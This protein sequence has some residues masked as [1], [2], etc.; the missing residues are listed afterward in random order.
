MT[1]NP[2][3]SFSISESPFK[4]A[5]YPSSLWTLFLAPLLLFGCLNDNETVPEIIIEPP[6]SSLVATDTIKSGDYKTF[7]IGTTSESTYESVN[8]LKSDIGLEY[9][10]IVSNIYTGVAEL[11]DKLPLYHYIFMDEKKGTSS[12]VQLGIKNN[13]LETLFL[14]SGEALEKWPK[15]LSQS[16][17]RKGDDVA[18][19]YDRLKTIS[20]NEKYKNKFEAINLL[21]KDLSKIYDN[22]MGKSPQWYFGYTIEKNKMDVVKLNFNEGVLESIIINHFQTY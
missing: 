10:N 1:K 12:G 3:N 14:S 20:E 5:K 8:Q 18:V 9:L 2:L 4:K 6:F 16:A 15:E 19:L 17:I 13:S 21:T 22:Q 7:T 11:E